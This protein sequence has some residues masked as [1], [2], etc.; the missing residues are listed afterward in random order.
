MTRITADINLLIFEWANQVKCLTILKPFELYLKTQ[1]SLSMFPIYKFRH[2]CCTA[3]L[4]CWNFNLYGKKK[5]KLCDLQEQNLYEI[6]RKKVKYDYSLQS[7][8][9]MYI[10]KFQ[11]NFLYWDKRIKNK[12]C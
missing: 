4:E 7:V 9:W 1:Q 12:I 8:N 3:L 2:F 5:W 10:T 11:L 6:K